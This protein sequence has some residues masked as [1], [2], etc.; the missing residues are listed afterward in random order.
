MRWAPDG[1]RTVTDNEGGTHSASVQVRASEPGAHGGGSTPTGII[2]KAPYTVG[3]VRPARH[4]DCAVVN[5]CR[6]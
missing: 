1:D 6:V 5:A 3:S 4:N 2:N